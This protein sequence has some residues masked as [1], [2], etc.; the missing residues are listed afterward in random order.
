MSNMTVPTAQRRFDALTALSSDA[1]TTGFAALTSHESTI[2][3]ITRA[4]ST[5][6]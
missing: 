2:E 5:S 1:I 6:R 3:L 4:R